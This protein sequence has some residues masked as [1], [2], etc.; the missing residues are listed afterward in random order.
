MR[1]YLL[2]S[3]FLIFTPS[4]CADEMNLATCLLG[5][6]ADLCNHEILTKEEAKKVKQAE[7]KVNYDECWEGLYLSKCDKNLLTDSDYYKIRDK[8]STR[9]SDNLNN[10]NR[11]V[12]SKSRSHSTSAGEKVTLLPDRMMNTTTGK[13]VKY[14]RRDEVPDGYD[15]DYVIIDDQPVPSYEPSRTRPNSYSNSAALSAAETI[16][17]LSNGQ[18]ST[19][20]CLSTYNIRSL[21]GG[22]C[23]THECLSAYNIRSLSN[24]Q[25][26]TYECL[27]KQ[28]GGVSG[29]APSPSSRSSRGHANYSGDITLMNPDGGFT[30]G[31]IDDSGN[32]SLLTPNGIV[33]GD[34]DDSGNISLLTPN[35][36][37]FGDMDDSGNI[38]LMNPNGGFIFGDMD[39]SGNI[40]LMNADGGLFQD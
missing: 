33:F 4:L 20:E 9:P 36:F 17:S 26:A 6:Y 8:Y 31:D 30:F 24:G 25:C 12:S 13:T 14:F 21:S 11:I 23:S 18:C 29:Y 15:G 19:H 32:I 22:E 2:I 37:I 16:R 28:F 34:I 35:G 7:Y 39:D 40:T 3:G 10:S 5:N 38:S 27:S 1:K